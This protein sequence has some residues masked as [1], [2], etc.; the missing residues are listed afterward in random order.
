MKR[1]LSILCLSLA[2]LPLTG[3]ARTISDFFASEPGNIF[4]LL[5]RTGRLDMVDYYNSGKTVAI[6]NN[7]EGESSL[8]QLDSAYLKV[9]TSKNRIVEMRMRTAG[10]DTVITV[11]ETVMTPVP[12]SRLTQWNVHWQRF[13]SDKLFA[14][15]G[16]DDFIIRK[17]PHDLR[18]DLQDAMIFPLIQ[19]T[20]KGEGHDIIEAAHGL[21]QFLAKEEYQRYSSYLKPSISYRFN[22]L[23]IKPVK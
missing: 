8:L 6:A 23:K 22:G 5:T 16:I 2:L 4:P 14:M 19:L 1:L 15:P 3:M 18:A 7:L 12:D 21:E 9:Q 11:I 20:F 17:M 13:T 10:K